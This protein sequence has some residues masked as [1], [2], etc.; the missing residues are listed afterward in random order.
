VTD[1]T[2]KRRNHGSGHSYRLDGSKVPGVTTI[3]GA[4]IPKPGL[5]GWAG[6][7]VAEY[8]IDRL[9]LRDGH[10]FADD[11]IADVRATAKYP[12]PAGLPRVK[13][14]KELSFAPNRQRDAGA[15]KGG[16]VH[17]LA[18]TLAK[19]GEADVPDAL[20]GYVDAYLAWRELWNP[21]GELVERAVLN[22]TV[23]YA[24]TFDLLGV[25][26]VD[27]CAVC[28]D[29]ECDGVSLVDWK[30]GQSGIF[31]ETAL[32]CAGYRYAEVY[33][34]DAGDEQPMPAV[35]H[36]LGVWLR[37]DRTHDTYELTA[38]PEQFRLFRY[39]YE[40]AKF[41]AGPDLFGHDGEDAPVREV[42][43]APITPVTSASGARIR[44]GRA[45]AAS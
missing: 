22:R 35:D 12:I 25:L 31:G 9:V 32:Q 37:P 2:F 44:P 3:L 28:G 39:A 34:D 10:Y 43:S 15:N 36:C 8:V 16:K 27:A 17:N 20:I 14:A 5:I 11:L 7:T 33:I 13:L 1:T 30:T 6:S 45:E 18:M 21:T 40:I 41:L 26:G 19:N 38:G 42:I 24:G 29:S 23:F 4:G